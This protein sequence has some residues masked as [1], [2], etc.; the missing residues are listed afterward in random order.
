M[1]SPDDMD[2][3]LKTQALKLQAS[4][5]LPLAGFGTLM[6]SELIE[7]LPDVLRRY[8]DLLT[9]WPETLSSALPIGFSHAGVSID[10]WLGGLHRNA[11]GELLLVTAIP[12][13]I[14]SKKTRK[15]HR[16]IRPWVNHLVACACDLPLSTALVASDETLMLE[17]LDKASAVTTLNHLLTAW[18]HGMQEPLPVAVKTAFAWLGQPADKA[19][20]AAR[21]AYEGDGQTS[22][23]E[24]RESTALARQF[25]DFDA[26]IDSEEFAGWCETLYKPIYDAPWQSLSGGE[27]GA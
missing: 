10:G 3:A 23:G 19:E 2:A 13:S 1:V 14:G 18:L 6:Q 5:L 12:N 11:R 17:P 4:G 26:L 27:G 16:L 20:A 21:K 8:H 7:P 22:D 25:P 24:R 15:W 9:L